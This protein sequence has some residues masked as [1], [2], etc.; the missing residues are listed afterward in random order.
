MSPVFKDHR[1][2]LNELW[3]MSPWFSRET[4]RLDA[5]P[6][7]QLV[8]SQNETFWSNADVRTFSREHSFYVFFNILEKAEDLVMRS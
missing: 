2:G 4:D 7:K 5:S 6:Y 3:S 8:I 1:L